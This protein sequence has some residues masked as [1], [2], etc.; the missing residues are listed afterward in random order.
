MI[1]NRLAEKCGFTKED[2]L[3]LT[4]LQTRFYMSDTESLIKDDDDLKETEIRAKIKLY[5]G[6]RLLTM[7]YQAVLEDHIRRVGDKGKEFSEAVK[8][9]IIERLSYG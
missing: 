5:E 2:V 4:P 3:D 9:R 7:K 6:R 8:Q 1:F